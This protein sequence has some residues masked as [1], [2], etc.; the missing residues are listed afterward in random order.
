MKIYVSADIE[1]VAGVVSPQQGQPGN[2][3][4]ER[5]RR[6]MTEEVS[7][8]VAGA[9]DGGATEVLVNDSHGPMTNL[10]PELLDPR[11]EL[12]LGKPKPMNMCAGL[13]GSFG[14]AMFTG[15]H[16]GAGRHGVLAHTVNGFAFR[17]IRLNGQPCSEAT[18]NGA[19]AGSLGV[20][21]V[22]ISGDDLTAEECGE[23][24]LDARRV[25]TKQALGAR[26]ARA[27]SPALARER[28]RIEAEAA[29]REARTRR[30]ALFTVAP[31]YRLEIVLNTP[32]LA[33]LA[34]I[35]PAAER[36]DPVTVGFDAT[37]MEDVLGWVNTVSALSAFLR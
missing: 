15:Y 9:F 32:A 36:L 5:A 1:G 25:V 13:D 21:V 4:Y 30:L 23:H 18:L 10:I 22:L 33:D 35:I 19:Y 8:V 14:A 12:I 3:E 34:A 27:I 24:F 16:T 31:P 26:A 6:L 29:V 2:P 28:L 7:A 11:A 20:P 37:R 17:T